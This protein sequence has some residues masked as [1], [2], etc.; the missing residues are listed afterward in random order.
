MQLKDEPHLRW[1]RMICLDGNNSLK[2]IAQFGDR[3]QADRRSFEESDYYLPTAFVD[4]FASETRAHEKRVQT[5]QSVAEL[6][7]GENEDGDNEEDS[8]QTL[9]GA[10]PHGAPPDRPCTQNWKA[11]APDSTKRMWA[12]FDEAGLFASA[13]RHGLI[14][15]LVDMVR[16]GELCV[17]IQRL[18]CGWR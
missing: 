9:E 16:S 18:Y 12:I 13:C 4:H 15:W 6:H 3:R 10:P 7:D 2:R 5:V 1:S 8:E 14:L 17:M 11:A